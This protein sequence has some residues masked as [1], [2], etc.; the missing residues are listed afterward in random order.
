[1]SESERKLIVKV[2]YALREFK[3][4]LDV[5]NFLQ[6]E[7]DDNKYKV[8]SASEMGSKNPSNLY[9]L[10]EKIDNDKGIIIDF[11]VFEESHIEHLLDKYV[12]PDCFQMIF[13]NAILNIVSVVNDWIKATGNYFIINERLI[14]HD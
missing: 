11:G 1:M 6:T 14:E 4:I 2:I 10:L 7:T 5:K 13:A 8:V 9:I 12:I 3:D